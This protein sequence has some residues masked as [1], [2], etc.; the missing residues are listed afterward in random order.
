MNAALQLGHPGHAEAARRTGLLV[1]LG[2]WMAGFALTGAVAW[3]MDHPRGG[4]PATEST[5]SST[6][7][8]P[9]E[10]TET[11]APGAAFMPEDT[12]VGRRMPRDNATMM[13]RP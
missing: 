11:P 4:I 10:G 1:A 7:A 3:R 6:E 2:I 9:T 12:V 8:T 13:Q 5:S